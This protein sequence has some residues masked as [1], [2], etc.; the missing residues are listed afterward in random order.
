[1]AYSR[2]KDTMFA[3]TD[4]K[5]APW[6]VV[7]RRRQAPRAPELHQPPAEHDPYQDVI[8][9]V[10][11]LPPRDDVGTYVRPPMAEQTFVPER[12]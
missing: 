6:Y 12:Y 2:A 9:R 10:E 11:A 4:I 1:V 7:E 3:Y 8:P 5:Q